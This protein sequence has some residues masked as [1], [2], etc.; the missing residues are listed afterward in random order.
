MAGLCHIA[1][2][3]TIQ[4][5]NSFRYTVNQGLL[6]STMADINFDSNNFCWLSFPNG[7]QKFDGKKFIDIPVQEGL[8]DNKWVKFFRCKNGDLLISHSMGISKYEIRSNKFILIYNSI[9]TTLK[10][11]QF[12]GEDDAVFYCYTEQGNVIGFSC[13]SYKKVCEIITGIPGYSNNM[14]LIPTISQN[15]IDHKVVLRAGHRL[16]CVNLQERNL[17]YGPVDVPGIYNYF[18]WMENS[19]QVLYFKYNE[20]D[21]LNLE[22]YDFKTGAAQLL[23]GLSK[24]TKIAYR[25]RI[26]HWRDKIIISS[27]NHLYETNSKLDST[28]NELVDFQNKPIAGNS[29]I[30]KIIEDNYGNLYLQTINDGFR[31]IIRNS[32]PIKYYG[33][34]K[35]EDNYAISILPDKENNR[36]LV[37]TYGSGVLVFDTLQ[38]LVKHIRSSFADKSLGVNCIVKKPNGDYIL[39]AFGNKMWLLSKDLNTIK[40]LAITPD[41]NNQIANIGYFANFISG[42]SDH[43]IIKSQYNFYK[44]NLKTNAIQEYTS[45]TRADM[46]GILFRGNIVTHFDE[47]LVILDTISFKEVR[48]IP[49]KG[50]GAVRCF[51]KTDENTLYIGSNKGVYKLDSNYHIIMQVDK[52]SGLPDECIY[53]MAIDQKGNVWCST[54]KGLCRINENKSILQLAKEDGL[55]ENEFNTGIV[56]KSKDGELFFGGV[57]GVSSFFPGSISML[58]EK[59]KLFFTSIKSNNV[60]IFSDTAV[61]NLDQIDLAYNQ[62]SLAFD[63]IA[64]ANN[65]PD[66]YIYQYMMEG[67]DKGWSQNNDL[68]TVH[69]FL[70]PG[71]YVFKIYA[72]KVFNKDA[73]SMK[74]ITIRIHPPFWETWWFIIAICLFFIVVL[75]FGINRYNRNKF[76]KKVSVLESEHKVQLE[77]ERISRDLDDN[78]GAY[79]NAVLY[80][81]ELLQKES[82]TRERDKLMTGLKFVSKD[83]IISLRETIWA[84]KKDNFTAEECLLRIRN[85]MQPFGR[86]YQ[87]IQFKI[88]GEAPKD[89]ILHYSKALNL[90]RIVQE[91]VTNAI[92]H[93]DAKNIRVL[94]L[95]GPDQWEISVTDDG[96]GFVWGSTGGSEEGN[97]LGNMKQ[98]ASDAGFTLSIQSVP[99]SGTTILISNLRN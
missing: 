64:M 98:R 73:K 84:L 42:N 66:Q 78:I 72:S 54:N 85:F 17:K 80:N 27:N 25:S 2:G 36:I 61:W 60:D 16:Y 99:G 93:A 34:E 21:Q 5:Y 83:I 10:P 7:I 92:K 89:K 32:Y 9:S 43:A 39:S 81:T 74:E 50:T 68:Q 18:L 14:D 46:S 77:S 41:G 44:I 38:H 40:P 75:A 67:V 90:V 45:S 65:N 88:E 87:Q 28:R 20:K 79:A 26:Q 52:S 3:Q 47:Q 1:G 70:P 30:V 37:G 86:Y 97:G 33:T 19:E 91:A 12:I 55:Q 57:N 76:Q 94:S 62:N 48:R 58:E 6:Q 69:Y 4:R 56:A 24:P 35:K 49:F 82:D 71:K 53:A 8:P 23:T 22:R 31:K 11:I 95:T 96:K 15:I 59:V 29:D 13:G 63:F 51:L